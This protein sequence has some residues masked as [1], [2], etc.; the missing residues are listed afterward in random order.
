MNIREYLKNNILLC[1]GAMGTYYSQI[2]GNDS[3]FCEL[4]NLSNPSIIEK[5]HE[6]YINSGAKLIRTNT[7]SANIFTLKKNRKDIDN[8]IVA[9]IN[10]AKKACKNKDVFVAASIGPIREEETERSIEILDEYKAIAD[11]FIKENTNIFIFETFSNTSY[12]KEISKYIKS[13]NKDAFIICDFAINPD[14][15]SRDGIRASR[16]L[17]YAEDISD[18]DVVGLNC[19]SGPTIT[20]KTIKNLKYDNMGKKLFAAMPNAGFPM[21]VHERSIF[22]DNPKF[23]A[24]KVNDIKTLGVRILGGCCG[25]KPSYIKELSDIINIKSKFRKISVKNSVQ[26]SISKNRSVSK[27]IENTFIN[28]I[29]QGKFVTAVELSAPIDSDLSKTIEG[30]K[31]CKDNGVDLVTI[32]DSPMGRVRADSVII[33]SKIKREISIEAMPHICCRDKNINAIRSSI[34]GA[35]I[36]DIRNVLAITGDPVS[37]AKTSET[38]GVFNLNSFKLI[39][40]SF[41][42]S[43]V[44]SEK[45]F[46]K[47]PPT[48]ITSFIVNGRNILLFYHTFIYYHNTIKQLLILLKTT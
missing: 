17:S 31:I 28:K 25:T 20:Y 8:I 5:I 48:M 7:F 43:S 39:S 10:I 11:I 3:V 12:L 18:I 24:E 22:T 4:S 47:I 14:G 2:T 34:L 23:Y 13:I 45:L 27:V 26:N 41:N 33:A 40:L 36:E 46:S 6:E 15:F 30:A 16:I 42:N 44:I 32:P 29:N 21:I 38:K 1:D 19:A 37:D 9:G 35:Y